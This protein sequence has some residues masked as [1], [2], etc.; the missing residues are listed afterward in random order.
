MDRLQRYGSR[1]IIAL[2]FM[3]L[4]SAPLWA[5]D[6]KSVAV[7]PFALNSAD[8]INYVQQGILDMLSSRIASTDKIDVTS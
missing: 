5:K 4:I 1:L 8:N 7:L 3:L 6:K 2:I